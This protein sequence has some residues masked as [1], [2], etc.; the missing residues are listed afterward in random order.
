MKAENKKLKKELDERKFLL[1]SSVK[2]M[3]KLKD[4]LSDYEKKVS[5]LH[6]QALKS[7]KV[8]KHT[9]EKF[10]MCIKKHESLI[11]ELKHEN[12]DLKKTVEEQEHQ[13]SCHSELVG[14]LQKEL[15]EKNEQNKVLSETNENF[16]ECIKML[17]TQL[18]NT[19]KDQSI[20]KKLEKVR[21]P[22]FLIYFNQLIFWNEVIYMDVWVQKVSRQLL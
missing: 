13:S 11:K 1:N 15:H 9:K 18:E 2:Q 5:L 19:T 4:I 17:E 22:I 7:S 8:M 6:Q 12:E 20:L 3:E 16:C 10:C 21:N 14:N